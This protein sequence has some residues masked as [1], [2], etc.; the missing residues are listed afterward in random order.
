M[1]VVF[2]LNTKM[3]DIPAALAKKKCKVEDAA[4]TR[5]QQARDASA[6]T[7]SRKIET[8]SQPESQAEKKSSQAEKSQR[9]T[10]EKKTQ[11][12]KYYDTNMTREEE[13]AWHLQYRQPRLQLMD[14]VFR[15]AEDA[16]LEICAESGT[17]LGAWRNGQMV[18]Q[19]Q[20]YYMCSEN[21]GAEKFRVT[22]DTYR[23][24]MTGYS[25]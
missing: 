8:G 16:G 20:N 18:P 21:G 25:H 12:Y 17:L 2:D 7:T 19:T 6:C 15:M 24:L 23:T 1:V 22:K 13:A 11:Q 3:G 10:T 4:Q 14:V 9:K 5:A